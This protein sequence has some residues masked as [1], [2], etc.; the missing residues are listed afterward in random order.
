[1]IDRNDL[2][3]DIHRQDLTI[4]DVAALDA[5]PWPVSLD[6]AAMTIERDRIHSVGHPDR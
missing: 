2:P 5:L 3:I 1:V 6:L 4:E